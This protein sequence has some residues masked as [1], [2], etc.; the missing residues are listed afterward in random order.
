LRIKSI[1]LGAV[2][3]RGYFFT[4]KIKNKDKKKFITPLQAAK[5]ILV[6]I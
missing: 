4:N 5:K 3:T 6:N 1:Y 2:K